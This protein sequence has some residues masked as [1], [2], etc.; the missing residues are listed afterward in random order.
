MLAT[1]LKVWSHVTHR[2]GSLDMACAKQ[3][4]CNLNPATSRSI[5][6]SLDGWGYTW[7]GNEGNQNLSV[8]SWIILLNFSIGN[9][10]KILTP[11][12]KRHQ[13]IAIPIVVQFF[14]KQVHC[15]L[16]LNE[17]KGG[18]VKQTKPN[19]KK[20][21]R[22]KAWQYRRMA[23]RNLVALT[24]PVHTAYSVLNYFHLPIYSSPH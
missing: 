3:S 6:K 8:F 24:T 15:P 10:A 5:N 7:F 4:S 13:D 23:R 11:L 22:R 1:F 17:M 9:P 19:L 12:W 18:L 20:I 16:V 2:A 21:W 14:Q